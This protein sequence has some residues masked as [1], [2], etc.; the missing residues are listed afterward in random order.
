MTPNVP[1]SSD[2]PL[3]GTFKDRIIRAVTLLSDLTVALG[4][5]RHTV[6]CSATRVGESVSLSTEL[7]T[8]ENG[9]DN[10]EVIPA[11][12]LALAEGF[13]P[14]CS[15]GLVVC[16]HHHDGGRDILRGWVTTDAGLR[17]L[18]A[19]EMEH[20]YSTDPFTGLPVPPDPETVFHD[21]FPLR[22]PDDQGEGGDERGTAVHDG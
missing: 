18:T 6:T 20:A 22:D 3:D 10:L 14:D 9:V 8:D 4:P 17:P 7:L 12:A 21:G 11:L 15:S 1:D 13:Q 16:T 19:K 2:T 5:G